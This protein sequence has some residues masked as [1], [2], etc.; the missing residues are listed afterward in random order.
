MSKL[1]SKETSILVQLAEEHDTAATNP[2]N[3]PAAEAEVP[4]LAAPSEA[5]DPRNVGVVP[6][7]LLFINGDDPAIFGELVSV[8]TAEQCSAPRAAKDTLVCQ[9]DVHQRLRALATVEPIDF[10]RILLPWDK[11]A[12]GEVGIGRVLVPVAEA[13]AWAPIQAEVLGDFDLEGADMG[14]IVMDNGN[15]SECAGLNL[16]N[17]WFGSPT[18]L[19]AEK[20]FELRFPLIPLVTKEVFFQ[21]L[22]QSEIFSERGS[23]HVIHGQVSFSLCV[24]RHGLCLVIEV[25]HSRKSTFFT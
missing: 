23:E 11:S 19:S 2:A 5:R 9:A 10:S 17:L 22:S 14:Q 4:T 8:T 1:K 12:A 13:G 21:L 25:H 3:R 15:V 24:F 16:C 20:F 6:K 18:N 7:I